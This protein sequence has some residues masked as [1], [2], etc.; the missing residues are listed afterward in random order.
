MTRRPGADRP[1]SDGGDPPCWSH[2]DSGELEVTSRLLAEVVEE[3]NDA[4]VMCNPEGDIVFWNATAT[5]IFGWERDE[6]V[7]QSL[8]LIIPERLQERHWAGWQRVMQTGETV[9]GEQLLEVPALRRDG[10]TIS[11]AF[12]VTLLANEPLRQPRAIVAVVRDQTRAWQERRAMR[13]DL[14]RLRRE[15]GEA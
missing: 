1:G 11:I 12:T 4:V 10:E 2:L 8:D 13:A 3:L 7:G 15:A 6:A 5:R 9:Y 14:D